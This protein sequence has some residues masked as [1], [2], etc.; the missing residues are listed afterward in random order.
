MGLVVYDVKMLISNFCRISFG[1]VGR[2]AN[3]TTHT[4]ASM[5]LRSS[6][7]AI[8]LEDLPY[9]IHNLIISYG[10]NMKNS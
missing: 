2:E 9:L 7:E 6:E 4:L 5:S 10:M 1:H 8:W 3:V